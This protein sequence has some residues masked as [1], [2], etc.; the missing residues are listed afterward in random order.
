MPALITPALAKGSQFFAYTPGRGAL[1]FPGPDI[2]HYLRSEPDEF[3]GGKVPGTINLP[4]SQLRERWTE[5]P[6]DREVWLTCGVGQRAYYA[7]R[8]LAQ[9]GFRVRNLSGGFS[10]YRAMRAAGI[11]S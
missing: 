11:V 3:A 10:T 1:N 7:A 2:G 5:L 4:L 9:Q 6:R 8:F